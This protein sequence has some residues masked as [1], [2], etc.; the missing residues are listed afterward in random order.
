MKLLIVT[1]TVDSDDPIL[2]F[3]H[4]WLEEFALLV[5]QVEVI[6]L[7]EGKHVLPKNVH[8]HSLGK[9]RGTPFMHRTV[10]AKRF[11]SLITRLRGDYDAVL[12]HMNPEYVVL[13]GPLWRQWGKKIGL[14]YTHKNVNL[15]LR[16]AARLADVIFTAS[17]E[18]FRLLSPKVVVTGHGI[19]L[20]RFRTETFHPLHTPLRLVS[21]GRASASKRLDLIFKTLEILSKKG[22]DYTF[23]LIGAS[24]RSA[25]LQALAAQL[26][27]R[28]HLLGVKTQ[29]ELAELLPDYDL[30]LHASTGTGSLDKAPLEALA[31]GVPA[32]STSPAFKALL[33]PY[34]LFVEEESAERLAE[35]VVR[36]RSQDVLFLRQKLA[37]TVRNGH[38]L[39]MLIPKLV[40]NLS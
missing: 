24:E 26:P 20:A 31:C 33:G 8:V 36:Y 27:G 1:Q 40:A 9:E 37:E 2:G 3:F 7:T 23:D 11:L 38:A 21:V 28:A 35:A 13:G 17:P 30:F 5:E 12:V 22:I 34:G 18:S 25:H 39:Q 15:K 6:C 10:Y 4:R 32:L 19:D 14:W 29:A 16:L